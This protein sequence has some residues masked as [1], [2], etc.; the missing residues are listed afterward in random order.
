MNRNSGVNTKIRSHTG[1]ICVP[2]DWLNRKIGL[3]VWDTTGVKR[4]AQEI[5][6]G[7]VQVTKRGAL[8]A[9]KLGR[10]DIAARTQD[11]VLLLYEA[12]TG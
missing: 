4:P 7:H 9:V 3:Y 10:L 6:A 12:R 1:P 2:A 5:P 11:N 8:A